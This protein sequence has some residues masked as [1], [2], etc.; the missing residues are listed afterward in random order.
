[1]VQHTNAEQLTTGYQSRREKPVFLTRHRVAAGMIVQ[2]ND[3]GRRLADRQLED[4][5]WMD[6]AVRQTSFGHDCLAND[7]IF[8]IEQNGR[9]YLVTEI[10]QPRMKMCEQIRTG[11][12]TESG[13]KRCSH[14][15]TSKLDGRFEL[16]CLR[17]P[18]PWNDADLLETAMHQA[19]YSAA[20]VGEFPWQ[21]PPPTPPVSLPSTESPPVARRRESRD[22]V[23]I[24]VR[25]AALFPATPLCHLHDSLSFQGP[26]A[27][28][29]CHLERFC[30][31]S[32]ARA[33]AASLLCTCLTH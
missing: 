20:N 26:V 8:R 12:H 29:K 5:A 25:V 10:P 17:M 2:E 6:D 19:R 33:K 16:C 28:K 13:R 32:L 3:R 27:T 7:G 18:D 4:L 14:S 31:G 9:K 30:T 15:T 23:S 1:M 24:G 22:L 11:C 21:H